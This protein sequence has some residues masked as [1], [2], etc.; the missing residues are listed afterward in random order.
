M[1]KENIMNPNS[2]DAELGPLLRK[3]FQVSPAKNPAFRTEVWAR[4]EANRKTPATWSA[5]LR[6]NAVRLAFIAV[7]SM[8]VAGTSGGWIAK[9]QAQQNREQLVQRYLDSLDPHQQTETD[10]Q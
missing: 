10:R 9:A 7:A 8:T 4:I 3:N 5:W 2:N 1:S 6:L